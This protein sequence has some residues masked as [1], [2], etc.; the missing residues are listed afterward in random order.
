MADET[1]DEDI[2]DDLYDEPEEPAKPAP[3]SAAPTAPAEPQPATKSEPAVEA[4]STAFNGQAI[5]D[6]YA[7]ADGDARMA[8]SHASHFPGGADQG[9]KNEPA[10]DDNY[11]PINVKEDG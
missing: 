4:A 10:V 1:F 8:G 6:E 2:F 7:P 5:K 3:A 9:V 11:G